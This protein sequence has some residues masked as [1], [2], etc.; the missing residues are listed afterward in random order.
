[1]SRRGKSPQLMR[2][3]LGGLASEFQEGKH[4]QVRTNFGSR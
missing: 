2:G 1:M 3:P 4:G